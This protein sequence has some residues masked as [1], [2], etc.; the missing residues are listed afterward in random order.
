MPSIQCSHLVMVR[1]SLIFDCQDP[2]WVS[3]HDPSMVS[4]WM[5]Q[6]SKWY[7]WASRPDLCP[8]FQLTTMSLFGVS[9]FLL[10]LPSSCYGPSAHISHVQ[11]SSFCS[12][13]PQPW[14]ERCSL[15]SPGGRD[16]WVAMVAPW[17][18]GVVIKWRHCSGFHLQMRPTAGA[19]SQPP[20]PSCLKSALSPPS[21]AL[22]AFSAIP[23]FPSERFRFCLWTQGLSAYWWPC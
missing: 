3:F 21:S 10:L 8:C 2:K 23:L 4:N 17:H 9:P 16:A 12:P 13:W 7:H 14:A 5:D 6:I 15:A 11:F 18:W 20:L 19:L 1:N 22:F